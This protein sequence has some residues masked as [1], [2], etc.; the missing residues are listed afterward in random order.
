[1]FIWRELP[2]REDGED[3]LECNDEDDH[4]LE[5][6]GHELG[7]VLVL[8]LPVRGRELQLLAHVLHAIVDVEVRV[9]HSGGEL[10]EAGM[11]ADLERN[12]ERKGT[13]ER[14]SQ[15]GRGRP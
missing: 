1:M 7:A 2:L 14:S 15:E 5:A 6:P 9:L 11:K 4:L 12:G 8:E 10:R 3:E 13:R